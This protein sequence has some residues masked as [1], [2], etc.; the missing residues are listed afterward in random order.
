MS[1]KGD[2]MTKTKNAKGMDDGKNVDKSGAEE[3]QYKKCTYCDRMTKG[4]PATAKHEKNCRYNPNG[5]AY[6]GAPYVPVNTNKTDDKQDEHDNDASA[7]TGPVPDPAPKGYN[8]EGD[9]QHRMEEELNDK[10]NGQP[11][12][13]VSVDEEEEDE[14]TPMKEDGLFIHKNAT[15]TPLTQKLNRQQQAA[16]LIRAPLQVAAIPTKTDSFQAPHPDPVGGRGGGEDGKRMAEDSA[17]VDQMDE[18]EHSDVQETAG[19][20]QQGHTASGMA[21]MGEGQQHLKIGSIM[22]LPGSLRT[23]TIPKNTFLNPFTAAFHPMAQPISMGAPNSGAA[24][25][26]SQAEFQKAVLAKLDQTATK[27]DVEGFSRDITRIG[28]KAEAALRAAETAFERSEM[29]EGIVRRLEEVEE[30]LAH[31]INMPRGTTIDAYITQA[32]ASVNTQEII[33][34]MRRKERNLVF[35]GVRE[36]DVEDVKVLLKDAAEW[37]ADKLH[38]VYHASYKDRL[39]EM[40]WDQFEGAKRV[41]KFNQH[42]KFPRDVVVTFINK[43]DAQMVLKVFAPVRAERINRWEEYKRLPKRERDETEP[44]HFFDIVED[45]PNYTRNR[46]YELRDIAKVVGCGRSVKKD[47]RVALVQ[48]PRGD[49]RLALLAD[50]GDAFVEI[51]SEADTEA[52]AKEILKDMHE[53]KCWDLKGA[54]ASTKMGE[55]MPA[56]LPPEIKMHNPLVVPSRLVTRWK[57][58]QETPH[59]PPTDRTTRTTTRTESQAALLQDVAKSMRLIKRSSHSMENIEARGE[60]PEASATDASTRESTSA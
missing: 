33:L 20:Q 51:Q 32:Q 59:P 58:S 37:L 4:I 45:Y 54:R 48:L 15:M 19:Q 1:T 35:K 17:S 55:Y 47:G 11:K 43:A 9:C 16:S 25:S 23:G 41:G 8:S 31:P 34:E 40:Y 57:A 14:Y 2:G 49:C 53:R 38:Q 7:P 46:G 50:R 60:A 10:E 42:R 30:K 3:R 18:E 13:D 24:D 52:E 36:Q 39:P 27:Q 6:G 44:P 22:P 56:L 21:M 26:H 12:D 5:Q 28:A 29:M